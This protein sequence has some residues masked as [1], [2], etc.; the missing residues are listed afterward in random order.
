MVIK[1]LKRDTKYLP[2]Q[3]IHEYTVLKVLGEGR[4]GICY[5]VQ[6]NNKQY[7]LKQLKTKMLKKIG[8]KVIYEQE[9][10][11]N[12]NHNCIPKFV[13]TLQFEKFFGYVL[14]YK[15][16]K[17]FEEIIC[18]DEYIFKR[19]EIYDICIQII[20][21]LKYLHK[22]GIVHRDI[23]IPNTI[24]YKKKVNLVDFGLAR[25]INNKRYTENVDFSYLGDFLLHLYYTSFQ[26][27][28][29]KEKPWYEELD[30]FSEEMNFLR[31]LLG[32][33]K[34]YKNIEEV[35]RDFLLLKSNYNK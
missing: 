7:I 22:S 14:E 2:E 9:I 21:I 18:E 12:I 24:Y 8:S 34:K 35:E 31:R 33:Q 4:F 30:L 16:G 23:R 26:C 19:E 6:S 13:K 11:K 5:L 27:K 3:K 28:T 15:E 25:W 32:I 10:L 29:F 20:E 1:F 17:T